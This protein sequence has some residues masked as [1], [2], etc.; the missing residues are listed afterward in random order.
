MKPGNASLS[1]YGTTIFETM[2]RLAA[3]KGALNLGQGIPEGDEPADIVAF[4]A[5]SLQNGNQYA[6]MMGLP[7]LR[8]AIA[9]HDR[10]F[11]GLNLDWRTET[12]V[13]S[14]G[15]EALACALF[16]LIEPGDEVVLIEPLYDTYIPVI[17]MAGGIPKIVRLS[18]PEWRLPVAELTAAFGPKTKLILFNSPMNPTAKVF[19]EAELAVIAELVL[20]HDCY[21][22]CDEVYEHLTFDGARHVPLITLPGMRDRTIR[23]A[24]AGKTFSLTG[25][26]VG[27]LTASPDLIRQAARAHQFLVFTTPPNLQSAV[28]FGLSKERAFFTGLADRMQAKRDRLIAGL[29]QAGFATAPCAGTFFVTVDIGSLGFDGGDAAFCRDII[30]TAGVAAI[31]VSEF[32]AREPETGFARFCFAK[33]DAILDEAALRLKRRFG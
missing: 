17:E 32:Y 25:W 6:P 26:K 8:Q 1:R 29:E 7:E 2:S 23:I 20:A 11:Y 15:T 21:A 24:S 19:T 27:Y 22:V 5:Q 4:A 12:M 28:A 14:G 9:A 3:N 10:D 18:P 13:T 31:P 16:G 33:P 30:E